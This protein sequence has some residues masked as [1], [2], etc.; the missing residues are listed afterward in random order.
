MPQPASGG[1]T[2]GP[3][4][5]NVFVFSSAFPSFH[6]V[7]KAQFG[8]F[9]WRCYGGGIPFS[10]SGD[11]ANGRADVWIGWTG[12]FCSIDVLTSANNFVGATLAPFF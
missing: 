7:L 10:T 11:S 3:T 9:K 4:W 8:D 12:P 5:K 2:G 1:S 6:V